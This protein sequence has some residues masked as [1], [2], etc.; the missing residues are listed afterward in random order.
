[1]IAI[2][3][4]AL[5]VIANERRVE[6]PWFPVFVSTHLIRKPLKG[7]SFHFENHLENILP[8]LGISI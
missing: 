5:S 3:E 7:I 6:C 2:E 1:L 4:K 8:V